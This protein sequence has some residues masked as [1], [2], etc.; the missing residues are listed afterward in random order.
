MNYF[1][2]SEDGLD[3]CWWNLVAPFLMFSEQNIL[4][5]LELE[6]TSEFIM[7]NDDC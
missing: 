1:A 6:L 3:R 4:K 7:T 2:G 5:G